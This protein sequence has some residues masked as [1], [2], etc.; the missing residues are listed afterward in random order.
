MA[1]G[2]NERRIYSTLFERT[3]KVSLHMYN[4]IKL[5][6]DGADLLWRNERFPCYSGVEV[7]ASVESIVLEFDVSLSG[8]C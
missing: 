4:V 1:V 6:G 8:C 7:H 5:S 3:H 2:T